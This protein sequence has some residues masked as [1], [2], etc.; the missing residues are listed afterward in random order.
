MIQCFPGT[1]LG[2]AGEAQGWWPWRC[3][4]PRLW[5][6]PHGRLGAWSW[7]AQVINMKGNQRPVVICSS[8]SHHGA[9]QDLHNNEQHLAGRHYVHG[10]LGDKFHG[11]GNQSEDHANNNDHHPLIVQ[12]ITEH[13]LEN[14]DNLEKDNLLTMLTPKHQST[15]DTKVVVAGQKIV[16]QDQKIVNQ[17][18]DAEKEKTAQK[19]KKDKS[20]NYQVKVETET[21][22][23]MDSK[24]NLQKEQILETIGEEYYLY[25]DH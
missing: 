13:I 12:N 8:H 20:D 2:K 10:K 9:F 1:Y 14:Q 22:S 4:C 3:S 16:N 18:Q 24:S 19:E 15:E 11:H 17:S 6:P 23:E 25:D 7:R 21:K 5:C